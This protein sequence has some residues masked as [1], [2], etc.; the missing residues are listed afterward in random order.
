MVSGESRR[1]PALGLGIAFGALALASMAGASSHH[2]RN[3][4]AGPL[5]LSAARV[6]QSAKR[7][8]LTLHTRGHWRLADLS[9]A[10]HAG[11][12]DTR[13]YACFE[14]R[15]DGRLQRDCFAVSPRGRPI[16]SSMHVNPSGGILSRQRVRS[17]RIARPDRRSARATVPFRALKLK[18]GGVGWRV[19]TDWDGPSCN[20]E[21]DEC[22]DADPGSGFVGAQVKKPRIVGCRPGK[23]LIHSNGSRE[24]KRIAL[25]FDDGPGDYT[26]RVLDVLRHNHVNGT[27]FTIGDQIPGREGLLRRELAEG[28]AIGDHSLHH[29]TR[30]GSESMRI[31][32]DRIRAAT[33]YSPCLFRP[34]GGAL[35]V[36]SVAEAAHK[37]G[38]ATILWD[39][40]PADW[41]TPGAGAIYSRVVSNVR[42][43]SI[44]L[45]HDGGGNRSQTIAALPDIIHTLRSRGYKMVTVPQ[46]LHLKAIWRPR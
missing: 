8:S 34:P 43:G 46:L 2:D 13:A 25:T 7:L 14:I 37:L 4:A 1:R 9:A 33:G 31:T 17:A 29:E 36:S 19:I 27:F 28:N 20:G 3:D 21:P 24:R 35:K 18:P 45:M 10:P 38:M 30:P 16:L 11:P 22:E 26:G 42:P 39:V 44:V 41:Q 12:H 32:R 15:Q 5:D 40:D 23:D 6:D